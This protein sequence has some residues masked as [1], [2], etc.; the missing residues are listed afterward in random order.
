LKNFGIEEGLE[1]KITKR[2]APPLGGGEVHFKCC[3]VKQ[4]KSVNLVKPGKIKRVRGVAYTTKVNPMIATRVVSSARELLNNFIPDVWIFTDHS[5]G[6]SS[7]LS[8]GYGLSLIAESNTGFFLSSEM[9]GSENTTPEELGAQV[10]QQLCDEIAMNG[11]V[12]SAHQH[13]LVILMAL[14]PEDV[15]CAKVGKLTQNAYVYFFSLLIF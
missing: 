15:S 12:D 7:G 8:P 1:L 4:L 13:I 14:C 2:G 11:C 5:K 9:I 6:P 3:V 10:S